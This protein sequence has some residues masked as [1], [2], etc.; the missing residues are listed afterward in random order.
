M[1]E[2]YSTAMCY[3]SDEEVHLNKS[4]EEETL[5]ETED[6]PAWT[7]ATIHSGKATITAPDDRNYHHHQRYWMTFQP[8]T[9]RW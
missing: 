5:C 9:S 7:P 1:T 4:V 3:W 8:V 6:P 2:K